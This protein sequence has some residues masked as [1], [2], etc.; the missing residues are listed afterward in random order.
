MADQTRNL[1]PHAAA[2]VAMALYSRRYAYEQKGGSMDFWDSLTPGE[3]RC[4]AR[5]AKEV[6]ASRPYT[7]R[8]KNG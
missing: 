5:I 4:C 1:N 2:R 7:G 8:H 6:R 3:K